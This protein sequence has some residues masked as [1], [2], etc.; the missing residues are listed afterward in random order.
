MDD[1]HGW[2]EA[3]GDYLYAF[4]YSRLHDDELA[5]DMVQET[6]LAAWRGKQ[7]FQGASSTRT[8]LVGI[9]KHKITD[10]IRREIRQR[11]LN[12]RAGNDPT[13]SYFD[14]RG[15][16]QEAP[17]RWDLDPERL[18]DN[19]TLQK[20]LHDCV[21]RLPIKQR[22]VFQLR[23][24][25]GEDSRDICKELDITSTHLHVLMHRARLALRQCLERHGFAGGR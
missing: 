14:H 20:A 23:E 25:A 19:G 13:S 17:Q 12:E 21:R 1:P 5:A 24:I 2:L 15:R 10:H 18:L 6:L 22:R 16:W 9:L 7:G 3:H 8:W 11:E 4:A